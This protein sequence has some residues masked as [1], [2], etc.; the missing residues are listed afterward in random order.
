ME[1]KFLL[2]SYTRAT[3]EGIYQGILDT[4]TKSFKEVT[5]LQKEVSPTYL[6]LSKK[7]NLYTVGACNEMG[8]LNSYTFSNGKTN[9]L[10]A[11]AKEGAAPCYVAVDEK[12]QLVYSA[13]YHQGTIRSYQIQKDGSLVLAD[14]VAHTG[15]GPHENQEK[16]HVHY[17]DLTPNGYLVSCDLG[18][19]EVTTYDVSEDGKLTEI[20]KFKAQA[21]TGPRHLVFHPNGEVAYLI[22]EL[23]NTVTVLNY[24]SDGHFEEVMTLSTLPENFKEFSAGGAIRISAD[25]KFLYASNRGHNSL[26]VFAVSE[27][28]QH[29]T[30]Q[31][32]ISSHGDFPRDFDLDETGKFL[33]CTHQKSGDLSLFEVNES[34]GELT[35]IDNSVNAPEAVCVHFYH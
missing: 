20:A 11:I 25:G 22:G 18:T 35:F 31:Q 1:E 6:T 9:F 8:S 33:V 13:N 29:L 34:T 21:G 27:N 17:T 16:A 19:D 7:S 24:F 23:A 4:N 30:T 12:R 3:S 2:G 15:S 10:N 28:G 14:E 26:I 32:I 5:L